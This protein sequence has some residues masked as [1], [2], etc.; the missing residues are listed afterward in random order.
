MRILNI[1]LDKTLVGI[2]GPGDAVDRHR[3]YGQH[4]DSLDIIVYTRRGETDRPFT[5]GSNVTGYPSNSRSKTRFVLDAFRLA[6]K[7]HE[8]HPFD[9]VVAQDPFV[10]ALVGWWLKRKFGCKLQINFHGDFWD[11]DYWLHARFLNRLLL[12]LSRFLVSQ[13]DGIRVMSSG[14]KDKLVQAGVSNRKIAVLPTPVSDSFSQVDPN[15]VAALRS[16]YVGKKIILYAGRFSREKNL[17]WLLEV[18]S[19]V[20]KDVPDAFLIL[21][22]SGELET[23]LRTEAARL[24]LQDHCAFVG[25]LAPKELTVYLNF[26]RTLVLPS[27]TESF[28]KVLVEAGFA[29]S[30]VTA[31]VTT[32]SREIVEDKKSGFLVEQGNTQQMVEYLKEL[33]NNETLAKQMGDYARVHVQKKFDRTTAVANIIKFWHDIISG[34]L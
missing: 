31:T 17:P 11:N 20:L 1:G 27:I 28:G 30:A 24:R 32:G 18:F 9:I 12:P 25:T 19:Q 5:I 21:A 8:Q 26:D 15:L 4:L 14:I 13:A 29:G 33:L 34:K 3:E 23:H 10:P 22:G 7:I 16:R 6:S 2:P